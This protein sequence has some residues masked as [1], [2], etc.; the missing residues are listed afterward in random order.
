MESQALQE[1]V[2]KI[3]NDE[4]TKSQFAANPE[5]ILSKFSLTMHEKEAVLRTQTKFGLINSDSLA[6][7]IPLDDDWF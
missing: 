2:R 6:T 1:L 5:S 3:F 4:E 7:F